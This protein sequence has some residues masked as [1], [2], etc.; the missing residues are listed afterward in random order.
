MAENENN[1]LRQRLLDGLERIATV[2]RE[3]SRRGAAPFGLNVAQDSILRLLRTR[4]SGLRIRALAGQLG[5]RQ[6]TITDSVNALERK[7][8]VA[9]HADPS[10]SRATIVKAAPHA[11]PE[12]ARVRSAVAAALEDLSSAECAGL[13]RTLIKLI[14]GLQ[15]RNAIPPQRMC[16]TCKYFRPNV[17]PDGDAPHYC[18]LVN[19]PFGD[20]ALRLDCPE[21][22]EAG[23]AEAAQSWQI[24]Q[25]RAHLPEA[26][27]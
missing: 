24:F 9:R 4:P 12:R 16:V 15:L 8:L 3:D 1:A 17:Y 18:A 2:L 21:H 27:E 7:G 10:D 14:R 22:E 6:P 5:V 13:L 23:P 26:R 19:A 25:S 11:L 20:R